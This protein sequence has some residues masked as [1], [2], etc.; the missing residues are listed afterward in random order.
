M[1]EV[2]NNGVPLIEH[3]PRADIT[4]A[5][6]SLCEA[7]QKDDGHKAP[8]WTAGTAVNKSGSWLSFFGGKKSGK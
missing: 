2:R 4:Q 8:E 1:A 7:L 3:A 5:F 6:V